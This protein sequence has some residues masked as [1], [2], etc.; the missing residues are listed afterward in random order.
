M[1]PYEDRQRVRDRQYAAAWETLSPKERRRLAKAGI[2]GPELP[3]YATGKRDHDLILERCVAP[4]VTEPDD[5]EE[6]DAASLEDQTGR[7]SI[8]DV[9]AVLR[10]IIAELMASSRTLDLECIS[11]VLRLNYDGANMSEIARRYKVTRAAVSKKVARYTEVLHT[12]MVPGQRSLTTCKAYARRAYN[13][14]KQN[15]PHPDRH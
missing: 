6:A 12:G 5:G 15:D 3:V 7:A 13:I 10:R 1:N 2:S 14:H 9:A 11:L 8:D 4:V